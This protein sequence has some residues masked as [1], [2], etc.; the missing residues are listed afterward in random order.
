M[1]T[2][3]LVGAAQIASARGE[4]PIAA[5]LL[6]ESL[7]RAKEAG[8]W[9]GWADTLGGC[10]AIAVATGQTET[11]AQL[12]A[13]AMAVCEEI[14]MPRLLHQAQYRRT[15]AAVQMR[16]DK[17][18]FGLAWSAGSKLTQEEVRIA[19]VEALLIAETPADAGV[20]ASPAERFGL[21]PRES[22]VLRLLVE[23]QSDKE[24]GEVLFISHRTVMGHVANLLAKLDV[25][26]RTAV[27]H[28]AAREGLV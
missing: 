11:A 24:I 1:L 3:A 5:E 14:G 21:T 26:S 13:A 4:H 28:V 16:L 12:L 6:T 10:A 8:Y 9:I 15:L 18:A 22:Q 25:P 23:G 17:E 19:A 20:S 7:A 2:M 27:A